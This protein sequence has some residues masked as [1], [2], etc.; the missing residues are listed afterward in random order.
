LTTDKRSKGEDSEELNE[1]NTVEAEVSIAVKMNG[2]S[3][4]ARLGHS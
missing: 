1:V 3:G 4:G 2:A